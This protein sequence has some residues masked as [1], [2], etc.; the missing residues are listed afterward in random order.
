MKKYVIAHLIFWVGY[1][2]AAYAYDGF[3]EK[4][5]GKNAKDCGEINMYESPSGKFLG[6]KRKN[7][8]I[9]SCALNQKKKELAFEVSEKWSDFVDSD[10]RKTAYFLK[11]GEIIYVIRHEENDS[12][13]QLF[14]G[15][16]KEL[17]LIIGRGLNPSECKFDEKLFNEYTHRVIN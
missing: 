4:Y 3:S 11:S 2:S 6:D 14:V 8:R 17:N 13:P 15:Y 12:G 9:I 5:L 7:K 16:C 10:A 1:S